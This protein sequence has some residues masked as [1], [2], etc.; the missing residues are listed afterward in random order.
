MIDKLN[1]FAFIQT[2]SVSRCLYVVFPVQFALQY[3]KFSNKICVFN[4]DMLEYGWKWK[5]LELNNT[6]NFVVLI[7]WVVSL[8]QAPN[9]DISWQIAV[10]LDVFMSLRQLLVAVSK[11]W[12]Y[13][14][15]LGTHLS[16]S[17]FWSK[18]PGVGSELAS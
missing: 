15:V 8:F 6:L 18:V 5:V 11:R 2:R 3:S 9:E 16:H 10:T 17:L 14:S 4:C 7:F 1:F 12:K 13:L